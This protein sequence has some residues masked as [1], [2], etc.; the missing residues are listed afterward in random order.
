[1]I[2]MRL[3]LWYN[4]CRKGGVQMFSAIYKDVIGSYYEPYR[5]KEYGFA[6]HRDSTCTDDSVIGDTVPFVVP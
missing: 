6:F 1:M 5:T 3:G 2:E 4:R